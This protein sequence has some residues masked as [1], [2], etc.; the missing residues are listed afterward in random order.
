MH[1]CVSPEED[2][3]MIVPVSYVQGLAHSISV[4]QTI[5]EVERP[6][7]EATACLLMYT[8]WDQLIKSPNSRL[9]KKH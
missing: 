8:K 2:V 9:D 7:N 5:K 6:G 4:L 1:I 3:S